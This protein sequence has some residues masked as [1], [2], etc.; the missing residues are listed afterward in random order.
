MCRLLLKINEHSFDGWTDF[1]AKLS[2]FSQWLC[3]H[4]Q[5]ELN[6]CLPGQTLKEP[7]FPS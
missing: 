6:Y 1:Y 7:V 3:E 5:R 4:H 2:V